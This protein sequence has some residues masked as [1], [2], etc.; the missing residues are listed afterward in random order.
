MHV[1][2]HINEKIHKNLRNTGEGGKY[3]GNCLVGS[4][5]IVCVWVT[6]WVRALTQILTQTV[7]EQKTKKNT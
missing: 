4:S 5:E 3:D 2:V 7:S 1:C 6:A